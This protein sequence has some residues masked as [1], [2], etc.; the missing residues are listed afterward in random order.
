MLSTP[1]NF[2]PLNAHQAHERKS[3]L[4]FLRDELLLREDLSLPEQ[5]TCQTLLEPG[6]GTHAIGMLGEHYYQAAW[7]IGRAH[8]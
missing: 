4:L 3:T 6:M 7:E 5:E 1:D 2:V 8:V